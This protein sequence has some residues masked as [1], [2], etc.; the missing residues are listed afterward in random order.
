MCYYH[1]IMARPIPSYKKIVILKPG[2]VPE[3]PPKLQESTYVAPSPMRDYTK[4]VA[5]IEREATE[6]ARLQLEKEQREA[7]VPAKLPETS[8]ML[9][10]GELRNRVMKLMN[11]KNYD[12]IR[13]LIKTA[14]NNTVDLKF[15]TNIH[16]ALME[17]V[18]P[19]LKS[20]D[21]QVSGD[22]QLT[23]NVV[24]FSQASGQ[25]IAPNREAIPVRATEVAS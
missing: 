3:L 20:T 9:T 19:K 5:E 13:E 17:F 18:Y 22:L 2:E 15:R 23:L 12:P 7:V 24:K 16:L 11:E 4:T 14:S 8:K 6:R 10:T 1:Q 25:Q 21:L